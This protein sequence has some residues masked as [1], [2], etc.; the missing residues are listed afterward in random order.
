M[1]RLGVPG[2]SADRPGGDKPAQAVDPVCGMTVVVG[3]STPHRQVDGVD[4]WFCGTHCRD[5]LRRLSTSMGAGGSMAMGPVEL[6][7]RLD[8]VGYLADDGLGHRAVAFAGPRPA[9]T[10]RG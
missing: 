8:E 10:A 3:P 2:P 1:A 5:S 4:V 9:H 7:R 6:Q